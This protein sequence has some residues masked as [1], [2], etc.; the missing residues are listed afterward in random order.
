M[1]TSD[2]FNE[3][4]LSLNEEEKQRII[5]SDKEY[6]V[7][8]LSIFN[9]GSVVNCVLTNN[10]TRYQNVSND[11]DAIVE[12]SEVANVITEDNEKNQISRNIEENVAKL[13]E[14]LDGR[15]HRRAIFT[16]FRNTDEAHK[17]PWINGTEIAIRKLY[18]YE[19]A[20]GDYLLGLELCYFI[21]NE[22]SNAVN[23]Y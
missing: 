19:K 20:S 6:C 18:Q 17:F 23:K 3:V 7:L 21:T 1:I 5:G 4:V 2:N 8:F 9:A 12:I 15:T 14:H 13:F 22:I 16:H 11:G 10:F